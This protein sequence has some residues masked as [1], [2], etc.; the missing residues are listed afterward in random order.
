MKN[1]SIQLNGKI[2][3][4]KNLQKL[5]VANEPENSWRNVIFHFLKNWFDASET[6][7]AQTSG[8]TGAPKDIRLTKQSMINSARMT[9]QFF[10]LTSGKSAL[11]CLPA[12][13]IAGK[14]ML[15]R[16]LVSGFN[17]IAVEPKANPFE[18]LNVPIDFASITPY[19]LF[20]SAETLKNAPIKNII[21]GGGRVNSKLEAIAASISA[22]VYE[23]YG[24]TETCSHIA[25]R[26]FNGY[27]KSDFFTVLEGVSIGQNEIS[28]LTIRAPHLLSDEIQTNDIVELINGNSFRW[29]GR[30]DSAINTGGIKIHPEPVEKKLENL[31]SKPFFVSSV[32]DQM[33]GNKIILVIESEKFQEEQ[34]LELKSHLVSMLNKYEIPKL[35]CYVP[36]FVYSLSD[37]VL[38]SETLKKYTEDDLL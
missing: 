2:F 7:L 15:V 6:I 28:C 34:E 13:Y 8:S 12:S 29:L 1:D 11:L 21:V 10:G 38:R 14:M 3:N 20:H 27:K 25:L 36:R 37:K 26:C 17:L 31:I 33:L 16:A 18:N 30:A 22:S 19:Q 9:N 5:H 32:P 4:R 24:M 35:I 23:T